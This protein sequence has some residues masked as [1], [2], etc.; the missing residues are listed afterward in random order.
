MRKKKTKNLLLSEL[1]KREMNFQTYVNSCLF[2]VKM[3][4]KWKAIY[5]GHS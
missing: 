3:E 2:M 4:S 1:N 5:Y